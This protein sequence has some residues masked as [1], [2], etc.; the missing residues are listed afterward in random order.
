MKKIKKSEKK[1]G[2]VEKISVILRFSPDDV[3]IQDLGIFKSVS[4]ID[5][6]RQGNP[7]EP[8]LPWKK[9]FISVPWDAVLGTVKVKKIS[10]ST[11]AQNIMIEA[12]QSDIP[13]IGQKIDY[14]QP[15]QELYA[16]D[17]VWPPEFIRFTGIRRTGGF[18]MAEL[19]VCPFR[20]HLS[21]KRLE[22]TERLNISLDYSQTGTQLEKSSSPAA[23]NH[24]KR[25]MERVK[26]MVINPKDVS[27]YQILQGYQMYGLSIVPPIEHVIITTK[28][29]AS[30][31]K[32]LADWR[33]QMGIRS[34]VVTTEDI[35]AGTVPNT[36]NEKFTFT[37]GY[38]DGKT[39]DEAEAIRNFLKWAIINWGIEF[40]LLGGDVTCIPCRYGFKP[41]QGVVG[42]LW[43]INSPYF[44]SQVGFPPQSPI[45]E[46]S[47]VNFKP[48]R[49]KALIPW[50][51]PTP[52]NCVVLT[53]GSGPVPAYSIEVS[54]D[55]TNWKE[56][57]PAGNS[58]AAQNKKTYTIT[59]DPVG[60]NYVRV[61]IDQGTIP[62]LPLMDVYGPL[63]GE[64][65]FTFGTVY[66]IDET[67]T[68][69][70]LNIDLQVSK[71]D[72][73][74]IYNGNYAGRIIRYN[75]E[76]NELKLGWR[77][78]E[79]LVE[80]IPLPPDT[81]SWFMEIRGPAQYH[82]KLKEKT[83]VFVLKINDV[84]YV[85]TDLYY[86][87]IDPYTYDL[88]PGPGHN[89]HDW[90][91]NKNGIYGERYE[92]EL[93]GVN[94]VPEVG[95]GRAPVRTVDEADIFIDKIIQYETYTFDN[96]PRTRDFAVSVLLAEANFSEDVAGTL[97]S[98]AVNKEAIKQLLIDRDIKYGNPSRWKFTRRYEDYQDVPAPDKGP[99]LDGISST[100]THNP[101]PEAINQGNNIV[102]LSSHGGVD[103]FSHLL[104][105]PQ[106]EGLSNPPSVFFGDACSTNMFDIGLFVPGKRAISEISIVHPG[107]AAVAYIGNSRWGNPHMDFEKAFWRELFFSGKLGTMLAKLQITAN[108]EKWEQYA[109]NLLGDPAMQVWSNIP[110]VVS[111]KHPDQ[112]HTGTQ[113]VE[114][115][116]FMGG[117]GFRNALVCVS[118]AS[119]FAK[120]LTKKNGHAELLIFPKKEGK[121]S[122]SVTGFNILPY[123]GSI[124]V[125][126]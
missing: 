40:V 42:Y 51:K 15:D 126:K 89:Y 16:S 66:R 52:I 122:I 112:I 88:K 117:K 22:L 39:R 68:R 44:A 105:S 58:A 123:T 80:G 28:G 92:V 100:P 37:S 76:C 21:E 5:A 54:N 101:I 83:P 99:D 6:V 53:W 77:F 30:K 72:Q 69:I 24:E 11:I 113:M 32:R 55:G 111:V 103:G 4:F 79:D 110:R 73:L 56:V 1:K 124:H 82:G 12:C 61:L 46:K 8:A 96:Q 62:D 65:I 106:I 59:F 90:D 35:T 108:L 67:T 84:N 121:L 78:V 57:Y 74:I 63:R 20:Y 60:A 64:N 97:D 3:R 10:V 41:R 7:G 34:R 43:D 47:I 17:T 71:F 38:H 118:S 9:I 120:Q 114:V 75:R 13:A 93:D 36:K 26:S 102:S 49:T 45:P 81:P 125:V 115:D 107:G 31:F 29:L 94:A 104:N 2:N 50:L 19:E 27:K 14:V 91:R 48:C 109:M 119:I 98:C 85:P 86:S 116:V 25:F 23:R 70:Y 18:A 33:T 87:D 95:V